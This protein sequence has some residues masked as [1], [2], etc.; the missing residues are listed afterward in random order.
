MLPALRGTARLAGATVVFDAVRRVTGNTA[1]GTG[2]DVYHN[3]ATVL[4]ANTANVR[5]NTPN[6]CAG[7]AVANCVG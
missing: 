3:G 4:L 2:G 5:G 1:G 6:N 7:D